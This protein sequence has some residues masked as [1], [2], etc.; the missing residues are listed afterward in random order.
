MHDYLSNRKQRIKNENTYIR[1]L[2]KYLYLGPLLFNIALADLFFI[3]SEIA[4]Y[5]D[6]IDVDDNIDDLIKSLEEPSTAL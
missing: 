5:V 4:S 6:D 2:I 3:I 1:I